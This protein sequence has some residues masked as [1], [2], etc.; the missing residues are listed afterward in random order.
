MPEHDPSL[1]K[2]FGARRGYIILTEYFK[3]IRTHLSCQHGDRTESH[4]NAWHDPAFP[5]FNARDRKPSQLY[6]EQSDDQQGKPEAWHRD[7]YQRQENGKGVL[8]C[9]PVCRSKNAHRDAYKY[10]ECGSERNEQQRVSESFQHFCNN[11]TFGH[12]GSS[13][14]SSFDDSGYIVPPPHKEGIVQSKLIPQFLYLFF[15]RLCPQQDSCR[16]TRSQVNDDQNKE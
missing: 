8:P 4:G 1:G 2:A 9:A 16:I 6:A 12:H 7:R 14:I 5:R 10:S 13:E 11:R 15:R 3:H